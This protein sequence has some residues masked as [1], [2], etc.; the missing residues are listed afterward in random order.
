M[1]KYVNEL[2]MQKK[3]KKKKDYKNAH[4]WEFDLSTSVYIL[5]S[6]EC[7]DKKKL[8]S[9]FVQTFVHFAD[10]ILNYGQQKIF[11]FNPQYVPHQTIDLL[12]LI[13]FKENNITF[14]LTVF[15]LWWRH[16][17][18]SK[19]VFVSLVAQKTQFDAQLLYIIRL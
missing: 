6:L 10:Q 16:A 3:K 14:K 12:T 7:V 2:Q 17:L 1:W 8:A 19:L 18:L 9:K 15:N 13:I 4:L 11:T 5:K